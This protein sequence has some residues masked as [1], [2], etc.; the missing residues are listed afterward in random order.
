MLYASF[1]PELALDRRRALASAAALALSPLARGQAPAMPLVG[2]LCFGSP[3]AL[4]PRVTAF[5]ERMRQLGYMENRTVRYELRHAN[6]QRDLLSGL[7]K[8][9]VSVKPDVIVSG[10]VL[11]TKPLMQATATIPIVMVSSEEEV[12][13]ASRQPTRPAANVTGTINNALE[14]VARSLY[15]LAAMVPGLARIAALVNPANAAHAAYHAALE[16]AARAARIRCEFIE[17]SAPQD[18]ARAVER[19]VA[20]AQAMTVMSD[21]TFY[22]ERHG[23]VELAVMN[24]IP[25]MYPRRGYVDVGGLMSYGPSIEEGFARAADFVHRIFKGA[26]PAD[27]PLERPSKAELTVNRY[28]AANL[29]ISI[30]A[31]L[32]KH[33]DRVVG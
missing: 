19:A 29:G 1:R 30:P 12:L 18:L 26:K 25:T 3:G 17:A 14:G 23:I 9:L 22:D 4:K 6:G 20:T 27:L 32:L 2:A 5:V 28:A 11:A 31:N 7:A 8:G 21:D 13:V 33:A 15:H 10:S 24:R 16:A